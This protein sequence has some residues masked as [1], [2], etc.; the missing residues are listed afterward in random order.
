[1]HQ[2][3]CFGDSITAGWN[4]EKDTPR[5]TDRLVSGLNCQVRNAGVSGE[6]TD[7]A[8]RRL[9]HD[10]LDLPYDKVTVLFGA[11]DSSFHKGIP[12]TRFI[13]NLDR[14]VRAISPDKVILMTPSPVIDARQIGKRTNERVSLYAQAVRTCA[15]SHGAV[16]ID[17]NREMAGK[18]NYEPL[19]LADGLHF[20]DAGY[21]FLA[22]LMVNKLKDN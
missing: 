9:D 1:M 4:G 3:I 11:N 22:G 18:D 2:L 8:V 5:L 14:I 10:V 16:L 6:T 12:L 15:R 20:S 19:L 13:R 21:D 17:L 7:Q